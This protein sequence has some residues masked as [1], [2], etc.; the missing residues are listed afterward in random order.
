MRSIQTE[1]LLLRDFIA[2]DW[3]A[4]NTML[5]DPEVTRYMHFAGWTADRRRDWFLWCLNNSQS[6]APDVYN[7]AIVLRATLQT[8]GWFG[9][10]RA[11]HPTVNGERDFGYLL[12]RTVWG[13]GYMTETLRALLSYEFETLDTPYISATCEVTNPA[14]ARVMEKAGMH[15][16]KT[17]RDADSDGNWAERHHY[18]IYHPRQHRHGYP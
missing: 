16:I 5:S 4:V 17:A 9:I 7:W 18:G 2:A 15:Y 10:G 3:E 8:I 13:Q 12:A 1:R 6:P 14:S 11:S